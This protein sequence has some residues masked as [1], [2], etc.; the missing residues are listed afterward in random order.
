MFQIIW[1]LS[2]LPDWFWTLVLTVGIVGLLVAWILKNVPMI[3][4]YRI[5]IYIISVT[6][7]VIGVFVQG[8]LYNE[9][10]YEEEKN[11]LEA[12]INKYKNQSTNNNVEIQEKIVEKTK[13]IEKRGMDIIKTIEVP[14]LERIK[15]ITKDMSDDQRKVYETQIEELKKANECQIPRVIVDAHNKAASKQE[16][17]KK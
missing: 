13:I 3:S 5:P 14:G 8:L 4:L 7:L 16:G 15:E 2:L 9:K 12:V 6:C 1:M 17:E 11:R 10:I